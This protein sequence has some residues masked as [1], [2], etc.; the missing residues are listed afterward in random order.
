MDIHQ[1]RSDHLFSSSYIWDRTLE[2]T[3]FGG[4]LTSG[5]YF[6]NKF[7]EGDSKEATS[8]EAYA[9]AMQTGQEIA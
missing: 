5:T 1:P 2:E 8:K 6:F 9:D 4:K 3:F 7:L